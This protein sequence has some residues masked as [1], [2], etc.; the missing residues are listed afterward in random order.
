MMVEMAIECVFVC[1]VVALYAVALFF[2]GGVVV[3]GCAI[4]YRYKLCI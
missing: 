4:L 1:S 3:R 2:G